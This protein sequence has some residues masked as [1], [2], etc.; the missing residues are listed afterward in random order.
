ME[1]ASKSSLLRN[2]RLSGGLF[3]ENILLR[4]RDNPELLNIGR[5]KSFIEDDNKEERKKFKDKRRGVFKWCMEK[6]DE[7]SIKIDEWILEELVEQWLIPFFSQFEYE[8]EPFELIEENIDEDNPLAGYI[9]SHQSKG[10]KNPFFQFVSVKD[11]LE[12][13]IDSN[14]KKNSHHN[15][16]QQFINLNPE[17]KWLFLSNGR[18]LRILTKYYHTYSKGYI[19][20]DLENIFANRDEKEFKVLHAIIHPSRFIPKLKDHVFLIEEFQK[21]SVAEGIKVGDAL[22]DNVRDALELL[23]DE[24]IQQNPQFLELIMAG[25]FDKEE[26]YA[27]LLRIIYRIIFILYAEQ[28]E[29]LP[30]T[31]S[32][33]FEEFSLSSIRMLAEKPIKAER[34]FDLWNKIIYRIIFILYAEQ[35]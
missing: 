20:F 11:D 19:E 2:I 31:G 21:E 28:R 13:K 17:I 9:I 4:L 33:Y 34:N 35:L 22:R 8:L 16:C 7:I 25:G 6:W 14:P 18:I 15:I 10:H 23:G 29:M 5:I 1:M 30:G 3:T 26:Y 32:I 24:L 12:S 27:E